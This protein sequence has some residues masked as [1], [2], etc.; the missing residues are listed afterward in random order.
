M[1]TRKLSS[2]VLL[3][4][5]VCATVSGQTTTFTYTGING[6]YD[7]QTNYR[8]PQYIRACPGT[9][10]IHAIM[11]VADDSLNPS[12]SRRTAYAFSSDGGTTWTT[13]NQIRIPNRR[14]GFPSLDI[15]QGTAAGAAVIANHNIVTI[16]LQSL[17]YIDYPIGS[18]AFSELNAPPLLGGDEPIFPEIAGAADGSIVMIA[19]RAAG[20]ST[21]RIRTSDFAS[22]SQWGTVTLEFISDGYVAE[23]NS[24]GRVGI[25]IG[26]P[27]SPL[28]WLESTDNGVT[29][30]PTLTNLLPE[31]IPFGP[32]TFG[33]TPGL[34]LVYVGSDTLIT[35]GVTK[36]ISGNL[37]QRFSGIGFYS[38]A[39]GFVLAV[40]HDSV[41]GAIDTLRKRQV[42]MFPVGCPAIGVSGSNIVIAFQ[43][44]MAETSQAGFNYG[45]IFFTTSSNGGRNWS[46]PS[47]LTHT[48][49][50]DERSVSVSKWNPP[51]SVYLVYQEDPQPGSAVFGG[52]NSP[53]ARV[54]QR[55]CKVTGFSTSVEN[56]SNE[57]PTGFALYQNYPN[58]FNPATTIQFQIGKVRGQQS[59]VTHVT[60]KVFDLLGREVATIVNE[61]MRP[62]S[63]EKVF[64]AE[65]LPS[66]VYFYKIV[67]GRQVATKKAVL[68]K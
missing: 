2:V 55:F 28:Q 65:G 14:S 7:Y 39:T 60:L 33:I 19:S 30:P 58:P 12:T 50:L 21:H 31:N 36:L 67:A 48:L 53:M 51:G 16:G 1:M 9:S 61:E 5:L 56:L 49:N 22:W 63:Y 47:N 32:D 6:Y 54:R 26:A 40:P 59:E 13:F 64:N 41:A 10:Y 27:F 68:L 57:A 52:D 25:A 46:Y 24:T 45:D 15:L 23:G 20:G 38:E 8:A 3:C 42:N 37:T 11:M 18:G 29:W 43:A 66:G 35:F 34:D 4:L 44:F 62:G 17:V